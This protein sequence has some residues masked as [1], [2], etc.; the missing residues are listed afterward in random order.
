MVSKL[1]KPN[2]D[3]WTKSPMTY[4]D[5]KKPLE[6][7]LPKERKDFNIMNKKIH[8]LNPD[9]LNIIK[10]Y[11]RNIN[12]KIVLDLGCGFGSSTL[13]LSKY[14]KKIF[15]IDLTY[16]AIKYAKKNMK[17]NKIRNVSLKQMDAE[18]LKF[19]NNYFDFVFS[20]GVIHH[21][22][23]PEKI[24]KNIYKTLK[25]GGSCFIMVYN[26]YSFRNILL[27][28]YHLFIKGKIFKGHNY[29]S[30]ATKFTDGYYQKHYKKNELYKILK[31]IG[32]KNIELS[33]GH[34]KGKILPFLKSHNSILGRYLSKK[35]GYFLYAKF[36]KK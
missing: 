7:R 6:K 30:I 28:N 32:Y 22:H 13:I 24:L 18:N 8:N 15:A 27:S 35:F 2:L 5:F 20:W 1:N 3:F 21:S 26:H 17:L 16:P 10:K 29:K 19:K 14:A 31:N 23:N 11:K 9:F 4:V 36:Q 34:H 12:E 25:P 33:I